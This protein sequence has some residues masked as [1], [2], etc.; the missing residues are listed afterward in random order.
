MRNAMALLGR[1][2]L[3]TPIE[4]ALALAIVVAMVAR[5]GRYSLLGFGGM[6]VETAALVLLLFVLIPF[7]PCLLLT[8]PL[9]LRLRKQ[10]HLPPSGD[11]N[12]PRTRWWESMIPWIT[13][14][15]V[16]AAALFAGGYIDSGS[17]HRSMHDP[18]PIPLVSRLGYGFLWFSWFYAPI[19]FLLLSC[20]KRHG[21]SQ[22]VIPLLPIPHLAG[23]ARYAL[24][25]ILV[26]V[27]LEAPLSGLH[28]TLPAGYNPGYPHPESALVYTAVVGWLVFGY[29]LSRGRLRVHTRTGAEDCD[30]KNHERELVTPQ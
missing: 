20:F 26:C 30:N 27:C 7:V 15:A 18:T 16:G 4:T 25:A 5:I 14:W 13:L 12:S 23:F 3:G 22:S 29:E 19:P 2:I 8:A 28:F 9:A 17:I 11:A 24:A 10:A 1:K 6:I 21:S